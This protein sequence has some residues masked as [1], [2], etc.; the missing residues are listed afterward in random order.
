MR[1]ANAISFSSWQHNSS[2]LAGTAGGVL[3][4]GIS[5]NPNFGATAEIGVSFTAVASGGTATAFQWA[6]LEAG[7]LSGAASASYVP[8]PGDDGQSLFCKVVIQG[9]ETSSQVYA[10]RYPPRCRWGFFWTGQLP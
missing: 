3:I 4:A 7:D 8:T 6:T 10:V 5:S 9:A 1:I 2:I